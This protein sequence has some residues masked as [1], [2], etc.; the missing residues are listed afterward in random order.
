MCMGYTMTNIIVNPSDGD[1]W[2][3]ELKAQISHHIINQIQRLNEDKYQLSSESGVP[4]S[5]S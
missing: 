2:H 3:M 4:V 1:F 5:I